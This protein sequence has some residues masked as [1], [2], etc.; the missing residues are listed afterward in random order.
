MGKRE[1]QVGDEG[2]TVGIRES[3]VGVGV[4]RDSPWVGVV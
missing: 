1:S 4:L 2:I 3:R